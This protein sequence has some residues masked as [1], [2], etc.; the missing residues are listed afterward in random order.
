MT[1]P[2]ANKWRISLVTAPVLGAC[3][4]AGD[5]T[6]GVL[7]N[8]T[9]P[10]VTLIGSVGTDTSATIRLDKTTY[11]LSD[12]MIFNYFNFVVSRGTI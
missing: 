11:A 1:N 3:T 9:T 8:G 12:T 7:H 10:F 6:Y 2:A 5:V 4:R